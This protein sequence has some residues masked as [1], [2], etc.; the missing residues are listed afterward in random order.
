MKTIKPTLILLFLLLSTIVNAQKRAMYKKMMDDNTINFYTVCDSAEAYFKTIDKDKKGSGYKPFLRWKYENESKYAPSGNRMVDHFMPYKEY[1]RIVKESNTKENKNAAATLGWKSLGPDNITNITGNYGAGLGRVEFVEINKANPQEIYI[2]SRSGGLWRTNNGGATWSHNT[3]FL[4]GS[5][6]NAIAAD[7]NNFNTVLIN[8]QTG[9]NTTSFGIYK[10]TD[11]G[12][13]F[14]QTAFN[15]SNVG[16]GGLGNAPF[17]VYSIQ[18]HPTIANLVLVGTSKGLYRSTTALATTTWTRQAIGGD[19]TDIDFHPTN[20]SI[21][22]IYDD[23]SGNGNLDRI[24]KSTDTGVTYTAM[25]VL[26]GTNGGEKLK[27][28]VATSSPNAVFASSFNG[29]WKST[30]SGSTFTTIQNPAPV[31]IDLSET[32]PS[33]TDITKF[34]TGYVDLARSTDS[35]VTFNQ[36]TWWSLGTNNGTGTFQQNFNTS[37]HYVHADNRYLDCVNGVFYACTDGYLS[38]SSDNGV[39]WQKISIGIGIRENYN[40]GISQSN[41]ARTICGSQDNGT[42]ILSETGWNEFYGADGMECLFHPLNDNYVLGS[43]QYGGRYKSTDGGATNLFGAS[44]PGA[45]GSGLSDWNAPIVSDPNNQMTLYNFS[46]FVSKSIDFGDTWTTLGTPASFAGSSMDYATIAENNSNIMV[47]AMAD[48]IELSTD[49]GATF[50]NIKGT[51]PTNSIKDIAFDPKNDARIFVVYSN[52]QND[53]NKIFMTTNSGTTWTNVT[54]NLG[55]MPVWTV[56]VDNTPASNIYV[57]CAIGIYTKPMS[58]TTWTLYNTNLPN[59]SISELDINHGSNTIRTATWGRGLWEAPLVG[60]ASFPEIVKTSITN[61]PTLFT[62][63]T[64]V[65]QFVTSN[66]VYAGALTNI[67]VSWA[68]GTPTFNGTNVIPMSLVSGTTWKSNTALPDYPSGTKVFFKVTAVGSASDTSETYKFMYELK[69]YEYCT[70]S[71]NDNT[72][73]Q[74]IKRFECSNL[75]NNNTIN[76]GYTYYNA[77]PILLFKGQTYTAKGTFNYSYAISDFY[78]WADY[79]NDAEFKES[80]K[81]VSVTDIGVS[82]S[83][84][85]SQGSF[86]VPS[87]LVSGDIRMR[88]RSGYYEEAENSCGNSYGEV[89]DYLVKITDKPTLSFSGNTMYCV[90]ENVTLTYTGSSI[91]AINWELSNGLNTYSFSGNSL[92]TSTLP[93]GS[94]SVTIKYT[95]FGVPL[96][97][98]FDNYFTVTPMPSAV[99]ITNANENICAN[100]IKALT[101]TGGNT[102]GNKRS[103]SSGTINLSVPDNNLTTGTAQTLSV[104][105][106]PAGAIVTQV[107]VKLDVVHPWLKDLRINLEAPNGKIINLYNQHGDSGQNLTNTIISSNTAAAAFTNVATAAPFTGTFRASL[108]NQTTIATTPAVNS[109]LFSE[110][111]TVPNGDW[112]VRVYDDGSTDLGTLLNCNIVI[113]YNTQQIVWSPVANLFSDSGCTIPYLSNQSALVVYAKPSVTTTYVAKGVS[114]SCNVQDNVVLTVNTINNKFSS[115]SWSQGVPPTLNGTQILEFNTLTN[116]NSTADISGCSC[117]VNAGNIA[118]NSGH[119]LTLKGKVTVN[120]GSLTV[121]NNA[122]LL[123]TTDEA[124]IGNVI[125]KRNS[126]PMVRL[127]YTAWSS[128]VTG[129]Q[130]QAFSPN[131]LPNRFYEYLYT[132][133]TTAT[134]YQSVLATTNFEIGKGYVIRASNIWP[135]A[136]PT[137]LNGQFTGVPNNGPVIVPIGLGYNLVGNPYPSPINANDV[138][139]Q[140][141]TV[142]TLYFWTHNLPQNGAYVAQSNYASYTTLGGTAAVAGGIIPNGKIEVGQG[143]FVT[144]TG[145]S[146]TLNNS[147]RR[148][149]ESDTQFFRS[150]EEIQ[151]DRFWINLA[152]DSLPYNQ[153][154]IGYTE[155][156]SLNFDQNID[157]KILETNKTNMY[158]VLNNEALVIQGRGNFNATDE[159]PIGFNVLES[160]NYKVSI[161][162]KEGIFNSTGIYLKDTTTGNVQSLENPI[163]LNLLAGA[164]NDRFKIVYNQVL[165]NEEITNNFEISLFPNPIKNGEKLNLTNLKQSFLISVYDVTGKLVFEKENH[166]SQISLPNLSQ[167]AYLV[168]IKTEIK[169]W[170]EKLI[171]E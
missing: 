100:S 69:P 97:E 102:T 37:T 148:K 24:L 133:T 52:Y 16:Y 121:E 71:G 156:S 162:Q 106:V 22:Y 65:S 64:T 118:I 131:T 87:N 76:N 35:G 140:N 153:I 119:T 104:T 80:E 122:S 105:N 56:I 27:I 19:V 25:P 123:Q 94:Y 74:Y 83:N 14:T 63:K 21:I 57:G 109:T 32:M 128:P 60:R 108:A 2:G 34:I 91:G 95:L 98:V 110:L 125:V 127:D 152:S 7:P 155:N 116:Y 161:C 58:G 159:V 160:G 112:K 77:T 165:S 144:T 78:V 6:V 82:G 11:G 92:S 45:S 88:V 12:A 111:F 79:D 40:L 30:D 169:I 28:S 5:G 167:G 70:A 115:G 120:S 129:Q 84:I 8:V 158:S 137:V 101:A 66:I 47:A 99:N 55:N 166:F 61:Q 13:T 168:K 163:A 31:G 50:T 39:T 89:E 130:L 17:K 36:C 81:V 124:N 113:T 44:P 93:A 132:G 114:E 149:A 139:T 33:D 146:F 141:P 147:T 117:V 1:E 75:D 10:S 145:G 171:V 51:L 126:T 41:N 68:V 85:S 29:L 53:G 3:D 23:Y 43:T 59:V 151:I 154:L 164:Y 15:P 135:V 4:P 42:A 170:N 134:A 96:S 54:Y 49:G 48:K 103:K 143:F 142:G 90:N 38:K 18:Y 72:S 136:T 150:N 20:S 86:V 62:P 157:G 138:L 107:D 9:S 73:S 67:Y 26:P 46:K